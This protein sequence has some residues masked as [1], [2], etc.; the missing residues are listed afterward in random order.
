MLILGAEI[1]GGVF[2][3]INKD[4][5]IDLAENAARDYLST[6]YANNE[7]DPSDKGWNAAMKQVSRHDKSSQSLH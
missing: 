2:V 3:Y 1:G 6:K 7:R 5:Y 4:K